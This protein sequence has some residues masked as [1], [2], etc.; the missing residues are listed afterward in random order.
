MHDSIVKALDYTYKRY[1]N[2]TE[3]VINNLN[4]WDFVDK[5]KIPANDYWEHCGGKFNGYTTAMYYDA[6]IRL[7]IVEIF[8][9]ILNLQTD[10]LSFLRK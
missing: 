9:V 3:Y 5:F 8:L 2:K 7:A 1:L 4:A 6:L 10:I